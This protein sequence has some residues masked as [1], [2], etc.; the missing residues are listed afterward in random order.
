MLSDITGGS[1]EDLVWENFFS[2]KTDCQDHKL[3]FW[4]SGFI[5]MNRKKILELMAQ[6][7]R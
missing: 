7:L 5:G 4:S 3:L 2:T 6:L 1:I